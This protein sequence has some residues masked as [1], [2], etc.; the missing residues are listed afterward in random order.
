MGKAV[1]AQWWGPKGANYSRGYFYQDDVIAGKPFEK[2]NPEQQ[3]MLIQRAFEAKALPPNSP[4][5][6]K[7]KGSNGT[8]VDVLAY[9]LRAWEMIK[10]GQGVP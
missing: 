6:F 3:A 5:S 1:A 7:I 4:D 2:L 8:E 10:A 9:V